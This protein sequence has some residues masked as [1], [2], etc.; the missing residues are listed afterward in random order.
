MTSTP[1]KRWEALDD[2]RGL[3]IIGMLLS[4]NPGAW[5]HQYD[6]L[7]HVKW[8][9]M[10]LI[11]MVSPAFLF[12]VGA[13]IP[14][15]L[16]RRIRDGATRG[17]LVG[18]ILWRVLALILLGL[19][20][21]AYPKFDFPHLRL[22]GVLQRIGLAFGLVSLFVLFTGRI[23]SKDGLVIRARVLAIAAAF[24]LIAYFCLL[25][26][27][28]V[29][30]FGAPRFD[31]VGAW[32]AYVDRAV[33]TVAHMFVYWPVDGKVVFDPD[34]LVS[35]FP[36]CFNVLS[37]A[38]V[39]L[40]YARGTVKRPIV[41]M[42]VAGAIMMFLAV[43]L[44]GICPIIKNL[45]TSTFALFSVGFALM[46]LAGL[47]VLLERFKAQAVLFP[48]KVYGANAILAYII[49]FLTPPLLDAA[50]IGSANGPVSLRYGSQLLLRPY[51]QDNLASL[52]FATVYVTLVFFVLWFCYRKGWF[53]KL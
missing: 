18:H 2:L 10:H 15:S 39:G 45:W 11:D 49:C 44:N 23:D 9:G 1:Q 27:V 19:A 33:F 7:V 16:Q 17:Q 35:T 48:A 22:P 20:L 38:F 36:C 8:Q 47:T 12:C 32:P 6:A 4:L 29:P 46:V 40:L 5:E 53:L 3:V 31:P 26:F 28:P 14:L 41:T 21:T 37:G 42:A 43:A 51:M 13:V 30:G 25:Y 24:V 50:W 34:G 52:V